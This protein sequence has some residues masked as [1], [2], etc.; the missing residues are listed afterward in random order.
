[1]ER[2]EIK[3]NTLIKTLIVEN[4]SG[5][6]EQKNSIERKKKKEKKSNSLSNSHFIKQIQIVGGGGRGIF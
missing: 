2:C 5:K 3:T 4:W 1:M 6:L